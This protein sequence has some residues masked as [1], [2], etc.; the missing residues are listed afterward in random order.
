M[1]RR[2][3]L[4]EQF[5]KR[6]NSIIQDLQQGNEPVDCI[7]HIYLIY[8]LYK[9]YA[10][11]LQGLLPVS[12]L[13]LVYLPLRMQIISNFIEKHR[14]HYNTTTIK[15]AYDELYMCL[16]WLNLHT[17]FDFKSLQTIFQFSI[18]DGGRYQQ[19]F[20]KTA[21]SKL[22]QEDLLEFELFN[23]EGVVQPQNINQ[24]VLSI[25][26]KTEMLKQ[27]NQRQVE[28]TILNLFNHSNKQVRQAI[29]I[30]YAHSITSLQTFQNGLQLCQN[31]YQSGKEAFAYI[32]SQSDNAIEWAQSSFSLVSEESKA[33][34]SLIYG[35]RLQHQLSLDETCIRQLIQYNFYKNSKFIQLY[36]DS[37][38]FVFYQ[39]AKLSYS[40]SLYQKIAQVTLALALFHKE[41]EV[42]SASASCFQQIDGRLLHKYPQISSQLDISLLFKIEYGYQI[43]I[44]I[45]QNNQEFHN[46]FSDCLSQIILSTN[47]DIQILCQNSLKHLQ[48][49]ISKYYPFM[50]SKEQFEVAGAFLIICSQINKDFQFELLNN[51]LVTVLSQG[52]DRD[53]LN[54]LFT[55]ISALSILIL[56][57]LMYNISKPLISKAIQFIT[58]NLPFS[59]KHFFVDAKISE[60]RNDLNFP[61]FNLTQKICELSS[62]FKNSKQKDNFLQLLLE[63]E[64][65]E[66]LQNFM[67]QFQ[68]SKDI[69]LRLVYLN[70]IDSKYRY[71]T[72]S[73]LIY[74]CIRSYLTDFSN[75]ERGDI[76]SYVRFRSYQIFAKLAENPQFFKQFIKCS[77]YFIGSKI[78]TFRIFAI[79]KVIHIT[80]LHDKPFYDR[81]FSELF[82]TL[83]TPYFDLCT[84]TNRELQG[85]KRE[86]YKALAQN[87]ILLL[88]IFP[89]HQKQII[90]A[91]IYAIPASLDDEV[92]SLE[93]LTTSNFD[94]I[95]STLISLF[96]SPNFHQTKL[97]SAQF[98]ALKSSQKLDLTLVSLL[99]SFSKTK[100]PIQTLRDCLIVFTSHF[101][102]LSF[103]FAFLGHSNRKI[104]DYA[105]GF[106]ANFIALE[107][108]TE[109]FLES[110]CCVKW[111]ELSVQ[112][113]KAERRKIMNELGVVVRE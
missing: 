61:I 59:V 82:P 68:S 85:K 39:S 72:D 1:Y 96:H 50:F 34:I 69:Y 28:T 26:F 106:L 22:Q 47:H 66:N 13:L 52:L 64:K 25:I 94:Q 71:A 48:I 42:R 99:Y 45:I 77:V 54:T 109:L 3:E 63:V 86:I 80:S 87:R 83:K 53:D 88:N 93:I 103:A 29:T 110:F 70:L 89:N 56:E 51:Q 113:V 108:K 40:K 31:V 5:C 24:L 9:S 35:F 10:R 41:A 21:V 104:R 19:L 60:L 101:D 44:E 33:V 73:L 75:D 38:L 58:L 32:I 107:W 102:F 95:Q 12:D 62:D 7:Y 4:I 46:D 37:C 17:S 92:I 23:L 2:E 74:N 111:A 81:H 30:Y 67:T 65:G 43:S 112:E 79:E 76:G 55:N 6:S 20:V 16:L 15:N 84:Q 97:A 98:L 8:K 27:Y 49:D 18:N 78:T 90:L 105:A 36:I 100:I 91:S 11:P 14:T 57:V